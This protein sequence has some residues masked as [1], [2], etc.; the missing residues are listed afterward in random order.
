MAQGPHFVSTKGTGCPRESPQGGGSEWLTREKLVQKGVWLERLHAM[1]KP[2]SA[3]AL[4]LCQKAPR[5]LTS[6]KRRAF[7]AECAPWLM[8]GF[9][10]RAMVRGLREQE[11]LARNRPACRAHDEQHPQPSGLP[12]A[13]RRQNP[14]RKNRASARP[15]SPMSPRGEQRQR[16]PQPAPELWYEGKLCGC[17]R[18]PW[19][20]DLQAD[21]ASISGG[22][23]DRQSPTAKG[24][25][26]CVRERPHGLRIG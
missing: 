11:G 2:I 4:A 13:G 12:V 18:K 3:A 16:Y 24:F 26:G 8:L 9:S 17:W 10:A 14:A 6:E 25:S 7:Q 22:P 5:L 21:H 1:S 15:P 20:G 19:S 23:Q